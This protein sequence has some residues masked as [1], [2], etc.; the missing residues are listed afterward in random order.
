MISSGKDAPFT[1]GSNLHVFKGIS[2]PA[3]G[4]IQDAAQT[5]CATTTVASI[6]TARPYTARYEECGNRRRGLPIASGCDAAL[7]SSSTSQSD[8]FSGGSLRS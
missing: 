1:D 2:L 3:S 6:S 5:V 4:P 8:E 7:R